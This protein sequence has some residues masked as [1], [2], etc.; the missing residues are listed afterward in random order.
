MPCLGSRISLVCSQTALPSEKGDELFDAFNAHHGVPAYP[1][2]IKDE[3]QAMSGTSCATS[4]T[5]PGSGQRGE[6]QNATTRPSSTGSTKRWPQ[7][8]KRARRQNALIMFEDES[9]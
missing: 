2:T 5:G 3:T 9:G 6:R 4:W 7:L 1:L 8:K